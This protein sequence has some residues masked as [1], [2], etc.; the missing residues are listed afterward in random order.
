VHTL[1]ERAFNTARASKKTLKDILQEKKIPKVFFDVCNDSATLFA[2]FGVALKGITDIQ[3]MESAQ[4][5]PRP[6]GSC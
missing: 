2:H 3:L 1:G 5:R 6:L 4:G